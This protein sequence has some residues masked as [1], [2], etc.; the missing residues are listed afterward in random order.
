M[1]D[2]KDFFGLSETSTIGDVSESPKK[3]FSSYVSCLT[4][5]AVDAGS[6]RARGSK[7]D[8]SENFRGGTGTKDP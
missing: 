2:E 3:S 1:G 8:F 4:F 6:R 7:W 5:L